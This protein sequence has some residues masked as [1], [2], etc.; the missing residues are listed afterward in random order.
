VPHRQNWPTT[1]AEKS[2]FCEIKSA[3]ATGDL[4]P[5]RQNSGVKIK[6]LFMFQQ[7]FQQQSTARRQVQSE[8]GDP[9]AASAP[10][11]FW[12]QLTARV[13][14]WFE[15]PFGYQDEQGFHYGQQTAPKLATEANS[16]R[17]R[18]L[19]DRA[20][21]VMKHSVVLPVASTPA[22]GRAPADPKKTPEP[23]HH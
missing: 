20:D 12:S 16:S 10:V 5:V 23:V 6:R 1:L 8:R 2:L 7:E 9:V 13:R 21:H 4:A 22:P 19:T 14:A 3:S 15:V 18:V 11:G 17:A